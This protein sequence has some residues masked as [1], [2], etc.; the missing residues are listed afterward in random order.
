MSRFALLPT[1]VATMFA[2]LHG[3]PAQA[4]NA[5]SWV[6]N[7]GSDLNPCTLA[8]P[9]ATLQRA[10]DQTNSGGEISILDPGD[11]VG[12]I[13]VNKSISISNDGAGEASIEKTGSTGITINAG[14]GDII[15]LRG[16]VFDGMGG[17]GIAGISFVNGSALHIQ[18]CVIRNY[19]D[20]TFGY[21]LFFAPSGNS[22]L[23]VSDTIIFNN[24]SAAV[25]GGILIRPFGPAGRAKVVLD[26]V[27][28]ENNVE[29]LLINGTTSGAVAAHVIVRDSVLSGNAANGIHAITVGGAGP[30]FAVV[31]RSLM[32]NNAGAGIL[33]DGPGATLLLG[34]STI[35]RN[36]TG[37][38]TIN[39]GQ[40]ISYGN[41]KNNNNIGAEGTATSMYTAF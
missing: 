1:A 40:L 41:N 36:G 13:I 39:S 5:K 38:S 23:F 8:S 28:V 35:T 11:Y 32:A 6:S 21:G 9:C 24:G 29:G 20:A 30:A 31:E 34:S 14:G 18:N 10:H 19:E 37:V 33:A 4:L 2:L 16:L 26:R 27:H 17:S 22:Q 7:G 25:S 12:G 3:T 15:S